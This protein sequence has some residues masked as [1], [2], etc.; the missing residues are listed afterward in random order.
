MSG[1][2]R[3][4]IVPIIMGLLFVLASKRFRYGTAEFHRRRYGWGLSG[5]VW[6]VFFCLF[7]L[8]FAF[9][10]VLTVLGIA[11]VR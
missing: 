5:S 3:S 4:S 1:N 10:G 6:Q 8:L 2:I 11:H 9:L 7:G